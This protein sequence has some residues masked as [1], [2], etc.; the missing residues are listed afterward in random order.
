MF[1]WP[2]EYTNCF[3]L[4]VRVELQTNVLELILRLSVFLLQK[5]ILLSF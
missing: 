5:H 2:I 4:S 3:A 1:K